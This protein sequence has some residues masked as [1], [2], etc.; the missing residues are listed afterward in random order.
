MTDPTEWTP[1]ARKLYEAKREGARAMLRRMYAA[2][3]PNAGIEK[4]VDSMFPPP[5]PEH[6]YGREIT[7]PDS[8]VSTRR[9]SNGKWEYRSHLKRGWYPSPY[10]DAYVRALAAEVPLSDAERSELWAAACDG[11]GA[12]DDAF[13]RVMRG[14]VK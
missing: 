7:P 3:Y 11:E 12:V 6:T 9:R 8:G 5:P 13:V 4:E 2:N 14:E 1:E 10:T